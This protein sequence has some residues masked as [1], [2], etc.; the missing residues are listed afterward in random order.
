LAR[1][2]IRAD[3]PQQRPNQDLDQHRQQLGII[4]ADERSNAFKIATQIRLDDR[5]GAARMPMHMETSLTGRPLIRTNNVGICLS[6][7]PT[8]S[9]I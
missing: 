8:R 1:Q 3:Q 9:R 5:E 6:M 2:L 4:V 7:V